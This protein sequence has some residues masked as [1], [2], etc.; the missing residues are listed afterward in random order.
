[1]GTREQCDQMAQLFL[2]YLAICNNE[3]LPNS[4]KNFLLRWI[5]NFAKVQINLE[6]IAKDFQN[7][8][9]SG[10]ISPNLVTLQGKHSTC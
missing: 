7:F 9:Q 6:N 1:M 3:N 5:Q 4:I 2:Q 10:E 8:C